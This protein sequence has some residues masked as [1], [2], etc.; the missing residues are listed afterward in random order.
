M[1]LLRTCSSPPVLTVLY[2]YSYVKLDTELN[3]STIFL[4]SN[5][6][7]TQTL[8]DLLWITTIIPV[9]Q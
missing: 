3:R 4:H 8:S 2:V 1:L 5:Y 9:I 6:I 7:L